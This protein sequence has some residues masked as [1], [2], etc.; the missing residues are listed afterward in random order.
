MLFWFRIQPHFVYP[1]DVPPSAQARDPCLT[2][3]LHYNCLHARV[4]FVFCVHLEQLSDHGHAENVQL[5][6]PVQG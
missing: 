5:S 6:R 4:R 2:G 1:L 3:A